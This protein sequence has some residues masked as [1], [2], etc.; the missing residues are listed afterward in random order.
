MTG[1]K[2]CCGNSVF[3]MEGFEGDRQAGAA[4]PNMVTAQFG[5]EF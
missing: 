1:F 5:S 3:N 2:N 4:Y